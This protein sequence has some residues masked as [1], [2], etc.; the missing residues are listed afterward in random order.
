MALNII[1][2]LIEFFK[3]F[4]ICFFVIKLKLKNRKVVIAGF[5]ISIIL[6][7]T[8]SLII[9]GEIDSIIWSII[10]ILTIF[11]FMSNKKKIG[12]VIFS[13]IAICIID[14]MFG[15]FTMFLGNI[16]P[17]ETLNNPLMEIGINSISL[18]IIIIISY[19][20]K[21]NSKMVNNYYVSTKYLLGFIIGGIALATYITSIQWFEFD[22]GQ[23]NLKSIIVLCISI[24]SLAFVIICVLLLYNK[25]QNNYLKKE[26][27]MNQELLKAQENYYMMLLKKEDETRRFR[28][29]IKNHF[30]C[31]NT[32]MENQEYDQLREYFSRLDVTLKN[33]K[34]GINTGNRLVNVILNN[35]SSKY[36]EVKIVWNGL[37]MEN[38]NIASIDLCTVFSNL[39]SNAFE[40]ANQTND[41]KVKVTIKS[42][43]S[44]LFLTI[45][46]SAKIEP[47]VVDGYFISSKKE[48]GH[49]YGVRNVKE[50]VEKNGGL[51]DISFGDEKFIAEVI[52]LGVITN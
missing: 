37:L 41:K 3:V 18:V 5:L 40:A 2:Y 1:L 39:L 15:A 4:L 24:S 22:N 23:K 42:L 34:K 13:D 48:K 16:S 43:E 49:G 11:T 33:I 47:R 46:N 9:K 20:S 35:I 17:E 36:G 32:L 19:I 7:S 25:N 6:V 31:M 28:H 21:N 38:V 8:I 12:I 44:N 10:S 52:F 26:A 45:E 50:C 27:E 30:Y 29:D 51:F 14:M